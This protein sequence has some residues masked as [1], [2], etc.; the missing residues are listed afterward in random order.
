MQANASR[1]LWAVVVVIAA[2]L[3]LAARVLGQAVDP[4]PPPENYYAAGNRLEVRG[5][6][7]G[8][9]LLAGRDIII[10]Q[11]VDGDVLG[12]GWRVTLNAAAHDDV[13]VA[14]AE[15][16]LAAPVDGDVTI[17]G[18]QVTTGPALRVAGRSW[19]SGGTVRVE[20]AFAR[21]LRVAGRTVQLGAE[22]QGPVEITAETV[23]ILAGA[24]LHGPLTYR[25]PKPA[26]IAA[27]A[28]L[29]G[30]VVFKQIESEEARR[31]SSFRGVSSVLFAAHLLAV[32]LLFVALLPR[33]AGDVATM[34]RQ[35]PG[36]SLLAGGALLVALPA[37]AV[38]LILSILG[39]P[40]GLA[41]MA[42][43]LV[44]LLASLVT[45]ALVVGQLEASWWQHAAQATRGRNAGFVVAGVLTLAVLRALPIVGGLV[46][47]VSVLFG[48]GA[49]TLWA[50]QA[51]V[52]THRAVA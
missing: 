52:R 48:L 28:V 1:W 47:L 6:I 41:L 18:G 10:N 29:G 3:A 9:A 21:D 38:V 50:W 32:G 51:F 35:Q 15:V 17:A 20:G 7:L 19:I 11:P 14:G 37:A 30:P 2:L 43:Y 49:L 34:L 46:V 12:A 8:D 25:S 27:G 5:P 23:E 40:L 16:T 4:A 36:R 31:A 42:V 13:R 39:L 22:V 44:A 24:R 33:T 26:V 45:T